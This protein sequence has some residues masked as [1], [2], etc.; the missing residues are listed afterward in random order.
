M[1]DTERERES[2][3][4]RHRERESNRHRHREREVKN[5]IILTVMTGCG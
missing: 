3:R 5:V 4:H 1:K 2:D